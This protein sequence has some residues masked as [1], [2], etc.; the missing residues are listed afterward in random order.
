MHN[1]RDILQKKGTD[2]WSVEPKTPVFEAL[3]FLAE[4]NIGALPVIE[5]G[6]LV[7]MFSER[8]YARKII[9]KGKTSKSTAVKERL[10]REPKPVPNPLR[11]PLVWKRI[12]SGSP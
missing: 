11:R 3:G 8:D 4:K 6:K 1:I 9:L 2:V 5:G 10:A 7:G 12:R